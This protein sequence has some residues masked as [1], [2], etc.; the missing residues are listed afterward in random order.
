[1]LNAVAACATRLGRAVLDA[2]TVHV[3]NLQAEAEEFPVGSEL[4]RQVGSRTSLAVP[5]MTEAVAIG[6]IY[7]RRAEVQL[8]TE[9]Q[10]AL[11]QT[12]ADQAVIANSS[13]ATSY[14]SRSTKRRPILGSLP[15]HSS[16]SR[17]SAFTR[18]SALKW[19]AIS[20]TIR[21]ATNI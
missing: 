10:V 20:R 17:F 8:F 19:S 16:F 15:A 13:S 3:A 1:V 11:L 9:R 12:F 4:A 14:A 2:R 21:R 18:S 7:L 6:A 5:L